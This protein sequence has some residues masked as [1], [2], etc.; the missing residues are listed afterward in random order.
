M[1]SRSAPVPRASS[2]IANTNNIISTF[3][4]PVPCPRLEIPP[5]SLAARCRFLLLRRCCAA[6]AAAPLLLLRC[7]GCA[8]A[9]A[10]CCS[11][12]AA[13][14]RAAELLLAPASFQVLP[15]RSSSG[16]LRRTA[17]HSSRSEQPTQESPLRPVLQ[18]RCMSAAQLTIARHLTSLT[19]SRCG[20]PL[21]QYSP[22][23]AGYQA[24]GT[25]V[26]RR[27]ATQPACWKVLCCSSASQLKYRASSWLWY[28]LDGC[29]SC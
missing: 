15:A 26:L 1:S 25:I 8:A 29:S 7:C 27:T 14:R 3:I 16:F 17:V 19:R 18:P 9:A 28:I 6:T 23:P 24:E 2:A 10:R 13:A 20:R 12:L 21:S 5:H 11:P 22:G 4:L